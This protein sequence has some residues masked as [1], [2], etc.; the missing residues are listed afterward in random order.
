LP[1]RRR[2]RAIRER[3]RKPSCEDSVADEEGQGR[4]PVGCDLQSD[5]VTVSVDVAVLDNKGRFI[6]N[7]PKGN[8]RILEDNVPQQIS[9]ANMG[10]RR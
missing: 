9:T 10:E 7:I 6:P 1:G 3:R 4:H 8:F 5:T 2:R